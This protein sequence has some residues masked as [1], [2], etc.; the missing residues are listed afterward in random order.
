[1]YLRILFVTVFLFY[2]TNVH[3]LKILT[4]VQQSCVVRTDNGTVNLTSA[5][6]ADKQSVA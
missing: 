5:A 3:G 1:M 2:I 4:E 6:A